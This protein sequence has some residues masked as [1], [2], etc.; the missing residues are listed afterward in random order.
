MYGKAFNDTGPVVF[1]D[2]ASLEE[3]AA[4]AKAIIGQLVSRERAQAAAGA[5]DAYLRSRL[6]APALSRRLRV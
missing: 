6:A 2:A 5:R 3:A 1:R 4:V